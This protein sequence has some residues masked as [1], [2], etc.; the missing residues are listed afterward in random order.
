MNSDAVIQKKLR[1]FM[2]FSEP[3]PTEKIK[4]ISPRLNSLAECVEPPASNAGYQVMVVIRGV[5]VYLL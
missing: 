1:C 5:K 4:P 3:R 2:L